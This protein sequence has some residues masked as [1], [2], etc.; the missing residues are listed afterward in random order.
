MTTP[1]SPL[2]HTYIRLSFADHL[3]LSAQAPAELRADFQ[4]FLAYT[5][6]GPN[7][8]EA[9]PEAPG[10]V[11]YPCHPD[12]VPYLRERLVEDFGCVEGR[13]FTIVDETPPARRR[14][15]F[16]TLT[17]GALRK[18]F[19]GVPDTTPVVVSGGPD[20]TYRTP[21]HADLALADFNRDG[22]T[23]AE[24]HGPE[25]SGEGCRPVAVVLLGG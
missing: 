2:P 6:L 5:G 9:H 10:Y 25:H 21:D 15:R 7:S 20:H 11:L 13:S 19:D 22:Q 23:F 24:W 16:G 14:N 1:S 12:M 3:H 18:L 4:K 17:V 8:I